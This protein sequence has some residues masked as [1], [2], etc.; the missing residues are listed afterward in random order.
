MVDG[1]DTCCTVNHNLW[2]CATSVSYAGTSDKRQRVGH[3]AARW[4]YVMC[5]HNG[6][7]RND[8]VRWE[9]LI[10]LAVARFYIL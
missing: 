9:F 6:E 7:G 10:S 5:G 3:M 4:T 8:R 2:S 1:R